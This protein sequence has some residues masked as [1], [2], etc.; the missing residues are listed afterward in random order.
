MLNLIEQQ[1]NDYRIIDKKY[2]NIKDPN[3]AK[4][5]YL[6]KKPEKKSSWKS[7]ESK[8]CYSILKQHAGCL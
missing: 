6:I 8:G 4:Y 1:N 2:L 7:G 3:E 5:Q